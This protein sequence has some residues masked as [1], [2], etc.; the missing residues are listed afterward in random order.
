M[1]AG[2]GVIQEWEPDGTRG[3]VEVGDGVRQE[4]EPDGTRGYMEAG[5]GIRQ[6][7]ESDMGLGWPDGEWLQTGVGARGK[8][9]SQM[10]TG[11]RLGQVVAR[12]E[13]RLYGGLGADGSIGQMG[14][15]LEARWEWR[16]PGEGLEQGPD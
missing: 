10:D 9:W 13:Q 7:L 11:A 14:E 12:Q 2:D 15:S 3:P 1:R 6:E 16:Q 5:G 4:Q 8:K